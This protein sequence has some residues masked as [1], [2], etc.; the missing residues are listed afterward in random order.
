MKCKCEAECANECANQELRDLAGQVRSTTAK[1]KSQET[2]LSRSAA[3]V[4]SESNNNAE[5]KEFEADAF[6]KFKHISVT[7]EDPTLN[8]LCSWLTSELKQTEQLKKMLASYREWILLGRH[9]EKMLTAFANAKIHSHAQKHGKRK[10]EE[11]SFHREEKHGNKVRSD[12][13]AW[14]Q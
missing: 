13:R 10:Q 11:K 9:A 12:D 8:E 7:Y 3:T 4:N 5:D 14:T 6:A 1:P 2:K